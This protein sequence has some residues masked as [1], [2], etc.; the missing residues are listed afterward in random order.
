MTLLE[1]K[2]TFLSPG[3]SIVDSDASVL[4]VPT[5]A[6]TVNALTRYDAPIAK[7]PNATKRTMLYRSM[8]IQN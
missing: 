3:S 4:I 6:D 1:A 8:F 5:A 7:E 2:E